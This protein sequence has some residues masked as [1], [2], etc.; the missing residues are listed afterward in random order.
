VAFRLAYDAALIDPDVAYSIQAAIVD[1]ADAWSTGKGPAVA[2]SGESAA[3][4][5]LVLAYRPDLVKG[6]VT[7]SLTGAAISPTGA[8]YAVA[9][10]ID[11]ATGQSLGMDLLPTVGAVPVPF[12]LPFSLAAIDPARDYLVGARIVDTER[13]WQNQAGVPVITR[14]NL[15]ADVQVVVVTEAVAPGPSLSPGPGSGPGSGPVSGPGPAAGGT[16]GDVGPGIVVLVLALIVGAAGVVLYDR[17]R[18]AGAGPS[19]PA[20]PGPGPE[21]TTGGDDPT[22]SGQDPTAS[23]GDPTITPDPTA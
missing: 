9:V 10:L 18:A 5:S 13:T 16:S 1:G 15:I 4:I 20:D 14:G 12:S 22:G 23:G 8:A 19:P 3:P 11:P 2:P 21:P 7:G 6:E 17:S